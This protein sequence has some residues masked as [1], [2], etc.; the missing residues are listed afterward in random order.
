MICDNCGAIIDK[1]EEYCPNC[2][3][4]L[5][6]SKPT[7]KKYYKKSESINR[8]NSSKPSKKKYY[9]DPE[10]ISYTTPHKIEKPIKSRYLEDPIL[11]SPDYSHYDED[12]YEEDEYPQQDFK[13]DHKEKSG[14]G[15]ANIIILLFI[16]LILGFI[17]GMFM[18]GSQSIPQIPGLNV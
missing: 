18:F 15:I 4:E 14:S 3:M 5:L 11:E 2:G 1:N 8:E 13:E 12:E 17:V 7:K 10:P 6:T 16:A 9:N